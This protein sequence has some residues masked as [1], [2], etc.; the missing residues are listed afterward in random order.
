MLEKYDNELADWVS[1]VL[2][3]GDDDAVFASGYLQG[4]FAVV[5]SQLEQQSAHDFN[6]LDAQ[7]QLCLKQA[8]LE[9]ND[10]DYRLVEHA[11]QEFAARL[12]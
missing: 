5:L 7:M 6:A 9:L 8:Q 10:H 4:H 1:S 2:A 3:N 11:W 12:Q